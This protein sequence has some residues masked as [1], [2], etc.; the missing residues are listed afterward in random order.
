MK[1][2]ILASVI[3]IPLLN[4]LNAIDLSQVKA[5]GGEQ[6]DAC[7]ALLCLAG[8]MM[9]GACAPYIAKYFAIKLKKPWK[10]LQARKQFLALC[11]TASIPSDNNKEFNDWENDILPNLDDDCTQESLNRDE[12]SKQPIKEELK[13]N[14]KGVLTKVG[15]YGYRINPTPTHSCQ[16]LMQHNYF[17]KKLSYTCPTNFYAEEDWFNG[18]TKEEITQSEYNALSD[19]LRGT[20]IR[21][22]QISKSEYDTLPSNERDSKIVW[23]DLNHYSTLYHKIETVYFKKHPIKKDCWLV[24]DKVVA[25]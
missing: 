24:Q 9:G 19:D 25:P 2:K 12:K 16:L 6:G 1:K 20:F 3:L 8:G 18:Y 17:S 7:G 23:P 11:P 10:T 22:T 14:D 4:P 21:K 15:I 13:E 5:L